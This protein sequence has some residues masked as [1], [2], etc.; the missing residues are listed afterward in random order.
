MTATSTA[1]RVAIATCC[2]ALAG[3]ARAEFLSGEEIRSLVGDRK[4]Y[5]STPYGLEFPLIYRS[6]GKVAGD[7]SGFSM[8]GMLA[9]K[10]T[11][12]WWVEG[13]RLCQKWPTWYDG[14]VTC[15]TVERT[16]K[17]TISWTRDDGARGTARITK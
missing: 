5:L 11:G 9:P 12:I 14:R 8:A 1:L 10:E 13:R 6:N 7:A 4:V 2:T 3:N 15:F 17:N 16:G